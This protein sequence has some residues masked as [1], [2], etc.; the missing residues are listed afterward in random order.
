MARW[1]EA[2]L[3]WVSGVVLGGSRG[4]REACRHWHRGEEGEEGRGGVGQE[5]FVCR[6]V[7]KVVKSVRG[8]VSCCGDTRGVVI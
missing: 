8:K 1:D 4:V 5:M 6:E 2:G 7:K 3:K